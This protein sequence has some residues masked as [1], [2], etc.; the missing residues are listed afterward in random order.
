MMIEIDLIKDPTA[1]IDVEDQNNNNRTFDYQFKSLDPN[2]RFLDIAI[3]FK[4][5]AIVSQEGDN[6]DYFEVSIERD[7]FERYFRLAN[8]KEIEF[9][10]TRPTENIR[11]MI[12]I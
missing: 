11:V 4:E 10:L 3:K 5:P 6:Y 9:D 2:G 7:I 12:P 1:D 8:N